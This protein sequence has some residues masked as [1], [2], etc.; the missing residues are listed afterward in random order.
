MDAPARRRIAPAIMIALAG[1]VSA[2]TLTP[3]PAAAQW[4][5]DSLTNLQVLPEEIPVTELVPIMAGFT[6]ALGV[7]CSTCHVGEEGQPLSAYDFAADDKVLKRKAREMLRMV[8]AVN[9]THLTALEERAD[10]PVRVECFTCHR[11]TQLPRTL[12]DELIIAYDG[13]GLD[14]LLGRY[15]ELRDAEHGRA[16]YDFGE[17]PLSDVGGTLQLRGAGADAEAVYS[18]NVEMNPG[19]A[20]AER[21]Y[22]QVALVNAYTESREAGEARYEELEREL[23]GPPSEN[24]VNQA[25]YRVLRSGQVPGAVALFRRNVA[26]YPESWNVHDSLGEGLAAAGEEEAAIASY[27]RS[28]ELN[29]DNDNAREWIEKL[30]GG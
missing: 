23:G 19:S 5:P 20:F 4:P 6:R 18:L 28:L 26:A 3:V 17:V 22:T 25:G 10:P 29:P 8:R 27:R 11:G 7:R 13:G 30:G 2:L 14:A 16:K 9:E 12:Q 21:Q 15:H 24:A 1:S